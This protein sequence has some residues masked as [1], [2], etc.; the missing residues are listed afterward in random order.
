MHRDG[1]SLV[2]LMVAM[3]L[4][5]LVSGIL[6]GLS[7]SLSDATAF[8]EAKVRT[9][10]QARNAMMMLVRELRNASNSSISRATLPSAQLSYRTAQDVDGNGI[11]VN[12]N[13]DLELGT[14]KTIMRD[15]G[16]PARAVITSATG[17]RAI[18]GLTNLL[19]DEDTTPNGTL[20]AGEDL[21]GNGRLDRGLWFES[22]GRGIQIT[23]QTEVPAT[24]RGPRIMS[25]MVELVFPRN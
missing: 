7:G 24:V 19:T 5:A 13:K 23:I 2:E 17:T 22:V 11:A 12:I 21:N 4:L 14:V 10:D 15:P 8:Q 3:A 18:P 25:E 6:L 9:T 1:F 16:D 20:D